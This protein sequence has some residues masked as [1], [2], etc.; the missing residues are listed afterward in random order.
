[1]TPS[2]PYAVLFERVRLGPKV[3]RNRFYQVPHCC[4]MGHAQPRAAA[5]LRGVK[6]EGGWA[7]VGTEEAEIHPTSD[8]SPYR[9]QRI[10]DDRDLPALQA[11]TEAVHAYGSLAAIELV[12]NGFHAP[13]LTS[14]V[15]PLAPAHMATDQVQ[16]VQAR[17][18]DA[19]DLK[20][21][22]RW[23][24]EAV[25]RAIRAGFDIVYVYAGHNMTLTQHFLLPR[26]N[27]RTDAYGGPLENRLRLTRELLEE[28]REV[29]E[30]RA[31]V[32]FRFAV[33][34]L[35][36]EDGL[37]SEGEARDVVG[38]LAELPDLW[39]VNLSDWPNDSQTARFAPLEGYQ[40]PYTAFVKTLTSKPVVGVGR[41]TSPEAMVSQ[42]RRGVLDLIGAA[43]PSIA[44]PFLP[45][46]VQEGRPGDIRECI[47]CNICVASDNQCVPIRCTQNPTMGEEWRRGWH[48]ERIE[49]KA[50]DEPVL[51][52]GGGP[53]GLECALQLARRGYPVTLAEGGK[54]LGGR[55]LAESR[56]PGLASWAR[57]ADH[58]IQQLRGLANA[59]LF[60][61]SALDAGQVLDFGFPHV[62]LATGASWRRDG[63]GRQ[64]RHPI[65]VADRAQ[66]LTPDDI[67]AGRQATGRVVVYDDDHAWL[68]GVIAEHL[69]TAGCAV[70]LVTPAAEASTWLH[71]TLEQP[72]VQRRLLELG[73][74][75]R[76]HRALTA[77][78]ADSAELACVFTDR[79][80]TVACDAA[81]L[82]T[83]RLP[84][85][86]LFQA[87]RVDEVAL[88]AAGIRT[89][90]VIGDARA[91]GT[92]AAAVYAGHAAARAFQADPATVAAQLYRRELPGE[93]AT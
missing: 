90:E 6:A 51:V 84:D 52:V 54:A 66:V 42:V 53:A 76:P 29:A 50:S 81:V 41:F 33:E 89:L 91:P 26:Y 83:E 74:D 46:K 86:G 71:H 65:R 44:D 49:P 35:L 56:L 79:R 87:L 72:R 7:V 37:S 75:I 78:D 20:A 70:T 64:S 24:R 22:R 63:V 31:A 21:F 10:W 4:G 80:E 93:A 82:A 55:A 27:T 12:H 61:D 19:G 34:E 57:V 67:L 14:R 45:R 32:A 5:A 2:D 40:E 28:A 3:A 9:E 15:P 48:P 17:A 8:I 1:M 62:F 39:D 85:D 16:P 69:R 23:H 77:L 73:V 38:L 36:G 18:M 11:M 43:R 13:N 30:G 58:R 92:L 25:E 60:L 88:S 68:G 59:D 47:G